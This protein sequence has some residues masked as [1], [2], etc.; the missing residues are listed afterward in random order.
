MKPKILILGAGYGGI[1]TVQNLLKKLRKDEAEI[2][3]V[4]KNDYHYLTTELHQPAA[5]TFPYQK[6]RIFLKEI[7]DLNKFNFVQDEVVKIDTENQK[8]QLKNSTLDYDYLVVGLGAEPESFGVPGIEEHTFSKWNIDEVLRLN[9]HINNQFKIYKESNKPEDLTF[10]VSGGGFTGI[11]FISELAYS[12]PTLCKLY[13]VDHSNV[14]LHLIDP[15]PTV[16]PGFDPVLVDS[17]QN[18]LSSKGVE[19]HNNTGVTE[20]KENGVV[21]SNGQTIESRTVIWAAG[22]RGNSVLDNSGFETGRGRIT[23]DKH[24]KAPGYENVFIIGD[25][26]V[27]INEDTNRPYPPTAQI[28]MQMGKTLAENIVSYIRKSNEEKE[29]KPSIKGTVASLGRKYAVGLVFGKKIKGFTAVTMK[30]VIDMRYL[31]IVG[32]IKMVFKKGRF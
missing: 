4:N 22:V 24:L 26:A 27:F 15:N 6:T 18:Y 32:G 23:V 13:D 10:V 12:I 19:L 14:K 7:L 3:L 8:V 28:A 20:C 29:F 16:L 5:G 9:E 30:K 25:C 31:F 17:A 21:L 11:E 1:L 2:T